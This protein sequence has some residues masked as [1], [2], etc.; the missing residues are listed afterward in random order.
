MDDK[1]LIQILFDQ[2]KTGIRTILDGIRNLGFSPSL[3]NESHSSKVIF[4]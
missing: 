4:F 2:E 1:K 3:V